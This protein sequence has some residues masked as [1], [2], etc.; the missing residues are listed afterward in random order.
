VQASRI[1]NFFSSIIL[2]I[3]QTQELRSRGLKPL[4]ENEVRQFLRHAGRVRSLSGSTNDYF[5]LLT[6][7]PIETCVF[8][9]LMVLKWEPDTITGLLPLFLSSTLRRCILSVVSVC[10]LLWA[11]LF[12]ALI[13]CKA[14][15]NYSS[16]SLI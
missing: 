12:R 5:H 11:E 6:V 10:A 9:G 7:L 15:S 16:P 8:P 14:C 4:S 2:L 3:S 1:L 13:P